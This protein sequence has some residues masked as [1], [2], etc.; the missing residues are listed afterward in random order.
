MNEEKKQ[1]YLE[2]IENLGAPNT[3]SHSFLAEVLL[4]MENSH[5]QIKAM[6]PIIASFG[7]NVVSLATYLINEHLFNLQIFEGK[8]TEAELIEDDN[9]VSTLMS[10]AFD[11]YFTNEHL[12]YKMGTYASK[13][14]PVL[15]TMDLYL[16]FILGTLSHYK[17]GDPRE[18]LVVDMLTSGFKMARCVTSLLENGFETEAFSTWR[19]LHENECILIVITNYGKPVVDAYLRHMKYA[20]AFR[21]GLRSKEETDA[22]FEEIKA[23]MK[24]M[25]LKSKDMK[26]FIEYGWL[27]ATGNVNN[28][29]SG[30]KLNFRDGVEKAAKLSQYSKVYEM[31]SEIAHSSPLLIYS[32]KEYFTHLSILNLYESFFR[33]EKIFTQIYLASNN[34]ES[35]QAYLRLRQLYGSSL[36][37]SHQL[38]QKTFL[39]F[40]KANHKVEEE[41]K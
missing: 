36:L 26:K 5:D 17:K 9:Y 6:N 40:T 16:N 41:T 4:E 22:C 38:E 25:D 3:V 14:N 30:F 35:Q 20:L 1:R 23:K 11:K 18:T 8:K 33:L 13:F 39:A 27:S 34:S 29:E 32:R 2:L 31:S 7:V 15:S 21:S 10:V 28:E 37:A 24:E 19:T 12:A